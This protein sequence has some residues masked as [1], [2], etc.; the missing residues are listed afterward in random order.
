[1]S[2]FLL[3]MNSNTDITKHSKDDIGYYVEEGR[4][5]GNLQLSSD[6]TNEGALVVPD[7]TKRI[8]IEIGANSRDLAQTI[9]NADESLG[10]VLLLTFE[11][12][13]DKYGFISSLGTGADSRR[14]VGH[15]SSNGRM[16]VFPFAVSETSGVSEFNVADVD[17]CSSLLPMR[18][19]GKLQRRE[20]IMAMVY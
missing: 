6:F 8:W 10:D 9:I 3:N 11:P 4:L 17:G 14:R 20:G 1:M 7:A 19:G 13:V 5:F 15:Q 18:W 12:L 16:L 2:S